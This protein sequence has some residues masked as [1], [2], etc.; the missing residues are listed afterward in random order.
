MFKL[1]EVPNLIE[2]VTEAGSTEATAML[3]EYCETKFSEKRKQMFKN[4]QF[5]L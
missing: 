4:N 3:L 2:K 1:E 5:K